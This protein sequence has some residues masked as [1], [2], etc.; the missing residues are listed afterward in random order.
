MKVLPFFLAKDPKYGGGV[1]L[2]STIYSKLSQG[3]IS[4]V[5]FYIIRLPFRSSSNLSLFCKSDGSINLTR[6]KCL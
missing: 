2:T 5:K 4:V 1:V 6:P 3:W